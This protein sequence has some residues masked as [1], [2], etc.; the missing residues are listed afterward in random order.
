MGSGG[1][2]WGVKNAYELLNLRALNI[3][4]IVLYKNASF[5]VRA[6]YFVEFQEYPLKFQKISYPRI[7]RCIFHATLKF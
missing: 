6:R 7:E 5:N 1:W 3:F 4:N 2:G